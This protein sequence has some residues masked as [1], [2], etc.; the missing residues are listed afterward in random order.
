MSEITNYYKARI[1]ALENANK[2]LR[3]ENTELTGYIFDLVS[4][5]CPEDYKRVIKNEVFNKKVNQ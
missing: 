2:E 5:D 3:D 4:N 1:E